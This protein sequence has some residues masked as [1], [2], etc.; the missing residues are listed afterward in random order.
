MTGG[1]RVSH[2][3]TCLAGRL[4]GTLLLLSFA[5][6]PAAAADPVTVRVVREGRS[7]VFDGTP[8]ASEEFRLELP[9]QNAGTWATLD[10]WPAPG[11]DCP[12][13]LPSFGKQ[14]HHLAMI[15]DATTLRATVPPLQVAQAFCFRIIVFKALTN[16]E[17]T[18]V[19]QD[20]AGTVTGWL[21]TPDDK[22]RYPECSGGDFEKRLA[23]ELRRAI[24]ARGLEGE[25][26]RAGA[27]AAIAFEAAG[28]P[29]ACVPLHEAQAVRDANRKQAKKFEERLDDARAALRD[30]RD[31]PHPLRSPLAIVPAQGGATR[32]AQV[33]ELLHKPDDVAALD[34]AQ[35]QLVRRAAVRPETAEPLRPWIA[36]LQRVR[37]AKPADRA[38]LARKLRDALLADSAARPAELELRRGEEIRAARRVR[39]RAEPHARG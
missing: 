39:R 10:V 19:A 32:L 31:P 21:N 23:A 12:D 11:E 28:G 35:G 4:L 22:G 37:D 5:P 1:G 9:G 25:L 18:A 7:I 38:A 29:G 8:P 2:D 34:E 33:S 27:Q 6:W 30:L 17:A 20:A 13:D 26:D 15:L 16:E 3:M 36:G 14:V 24:K